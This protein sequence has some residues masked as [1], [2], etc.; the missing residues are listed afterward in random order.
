MQLVHAG[1]QARE[2]VSGSTPV[3]P[4]GIKAAQYSEKPLQLTEPQIQNIVKAFGKAALRAKEYGFDGVQIHGA[5][6]YL[7][8][9]FL[10]P[11]TNRRT[12]QYGGSI[13]NRCHF[14]FEVLSLHTTENKTAVFRLDEH[15]KRLL[16]TADALSMQIPLTMD[17][18][19]E[20]VLETAR[21]NSVKQGFI[22]IICYYPQISFEI[23]PPRSPLTVSIFVIDPVKDIE[24]G[25]MP[26]KKRV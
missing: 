15:I 22:K 26:E 20:K 6:G 1:G 7:V 21:K 9:Q 14:L 18:I 25:H 19:R 4:S 17:K 24:N 16:R 10:S 13:E 2:E 12:D 3:A 11:L 23:L 5:H 8:N